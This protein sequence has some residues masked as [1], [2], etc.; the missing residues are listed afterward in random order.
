[1]AK[2]TQVLKLNA[3]GKKFTV[4]F[5][6]GTNRNPFRLYEHERVYD[7]ER[8]FRERRKLVV[9]YQNMESVLYWLLQNVPEFRQDVW[10]V[11]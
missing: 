3:C 7:K 8:G 2:T 4:L 6:R 1:M 5:E 10:E 11:K 9:K